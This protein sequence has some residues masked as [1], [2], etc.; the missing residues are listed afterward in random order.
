MKEEEEKEMK[1]KESTHHVVDIFKDGGKAT[2]DEGELVLGYV[3][4]TFFV[5]L[6]ADFGVSILV[7]NFDGKLK[8]K[9]REDDEV[10]ITVSYSHCSL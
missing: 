6:C 7:A 5:V 4:Q 9:T 10:V 2:D 3:D 1:K 8:E